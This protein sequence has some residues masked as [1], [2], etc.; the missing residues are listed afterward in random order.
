MIRF[1]DLLVPEQVLFL[2]PL[3]KEKALL[4]L[5]EHLSHLHVIPDKEPFYHA[6]L[7]REK[8]MSTAIGQAAALP[9][10]KLPSLQKFFL[11]IGISKEGIDWHAD[12]DTPVKFIFLI[13]GPD[14]QPL[15]YLSLLSSLT[16]TYRKSIV[17]K[18]LSQASSTDSVIAALS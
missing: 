16:K 17:K 4:M 15:E 18:K 12:D 1:Q 9:H 6:L 10:A 3:S 14:N 2:P 11:S 8:L 7:Q 5:V 13:G